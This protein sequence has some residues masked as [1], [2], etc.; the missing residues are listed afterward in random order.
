[1]KYGEDPSIYYP[2]LFYDIG[3]DTTFARTALLSIRANLYSESFPKTVQKWCTDHGIALTGHVDQEEVI[4]PCG[5]TGDLIKSFKYQ[6][7]PGIDEIIVKDRATK[8]YKIVSSSA[9]NYNKSLVMCE[10][11]GAFNEIDE[12]IIYHE[13][14]DMFTKGVN[15]FVPHAVWY[16]TNEN[17]IVFKPELSYRHEYFSKVLPKYNEYYSTVANY[18]QPAKQVNTVGM[19]YPIESLESEYT[20]NWGGDPYLGGPTSKT[21]DYMDIGQFLSRS[22]NID[23]NFIH[24]EVLSENGRVNGGILSLNN[25]EHIQ[26]YKVIIMPGMKAVSVKT[27]KILK[28]FVLSGG[29]LISINE[30]PKSSS[31]KGKDQEV[32]DIVYELFGVN[33]IIGLTKKTLGDSGKCYAIP[34]QNLEEIRNIILS[35]KIDT[36]ILSNN[37]GLQYIHKKNKIENFDVWYFANL[38]EDFSSKVVLDGIFN[39]TA[40]DPKTNEETVLKASYKENTTEFDLSIKKLQSLLVIGK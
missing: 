32:R 20:L 36:S 13:S 38:G 14:Y 9:V 16:D 33:E 28:E 3:E 29:T 22:A 27:M 39:L 24:P 12:D 11:F 10:C 7:I 19:I 34:S 8:A 2:A 40:I 6:D 25:T 1:L 15:H 4:N 37:Y 35:E 21:D 26:N 5:M 30:L 23:Y 31:E 17:R 18:L